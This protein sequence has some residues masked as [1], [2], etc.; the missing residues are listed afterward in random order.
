MNDW[1]TERLKA[2][3]ASEVGSLFD[4][5]YSNESEYALWQKKCQTEPERPEESE[6]FYFGHQAEVVVANA[7]EDLHKMTV[8][9][10]EELNINF[11]CEQVHCEHSGKLV[12]LYRRGVLGCTP[13]GI[14]FDGTKTLGLEVKNVDKFS[15]RKWPTDSLPER[16][17]L[18]VQACMYVTGLDEWLLAAFVGGNELHLHRIARD[19][20]TVALIV[21]RCEQFWSLVKSQT[22][23]VLK[24]GRDNHAINEAWKQQKALET[25][26]VKGN[27]TWR[28]LAAQY[29]QAKLDE[30]A[31][32]KRANDIRAA[33]ELLVAGAK[34]VD[35][36]DFVIK[37]TEVPASEGKL[38]TSSMVGTYS[39][40]RKASKRMTVKWSDDHE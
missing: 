37:V 32:E 18:Q 17:F 9:L 28:T 23:P 29:R 40:A 7:L 33:L 20:E 30:A 36:G 1:L 31:A 13:D 5:G 22:P 25:L 12:N 2:V 39:G 19:E 26:D 27:D 15:Y 34:Y 6:L 38:I 8:T 24:P 3:Q 16:H 11:G 35:G 21:K 4:C 14:V 10:N